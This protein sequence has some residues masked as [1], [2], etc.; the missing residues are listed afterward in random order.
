MNNARQLYLG[1][2]M[3]TDGSANSDRIT[4]AG[5]HRS[6]DEPRGDTEARSRAN[7]W[8]QTGD[9]QKILNAPA[10]TRA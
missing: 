10:E 7:D 8:P 6:P 1:F 3:A 4:V 9:L 5:E 2:Q